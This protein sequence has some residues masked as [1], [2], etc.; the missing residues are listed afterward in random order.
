MFFWICAISCT[1]FA[2]GRD[3]VRVSGMHVHLVIRVRV[4]ECGCAYNRGWVLRIPV[5]LTAYAEKRE[6]D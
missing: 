4:R 1:F 6:T 5:Q 2:R 3:R